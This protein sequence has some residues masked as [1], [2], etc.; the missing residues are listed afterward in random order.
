MHDQFLAI[1]Q[2]ERSNTKGLYE[3]FVRV[4]S[5]VGVTDWKKLGGSARDGT[6]INI[7]AHGMRGCLEE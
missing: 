5:F 2:P 1:W 7:A 3:S 4:L 6:S